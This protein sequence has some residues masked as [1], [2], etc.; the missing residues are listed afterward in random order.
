MRRGLLIQ[1]LSR[2][3]LVAI[4]TPSGSGSPSTFTLFATSDVNGLDPILTSNTSGILATININPDTGLAIAQST[5]SNL[6]FV[7][8]PGSIAL[9]GSGLA[10]LLLWSRRRRS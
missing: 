4:S 7:P 6:Q 2:L 3:T 1:P 10:G 8:E 5:T 9:L